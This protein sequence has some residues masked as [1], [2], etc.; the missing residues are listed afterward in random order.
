[1]KRRL[2]SESVRCAFFAALCLALCSGCSTV[3]SLLAKPVP[4]PP[5]AKLVFSDDFSKGLDNW[6]TEGVGSLAVV[7]GA[8]VMDPRVQNYDGYQARNLWCKQPL[9]VNF[10]ITM[11]VH[12]IA[13]TPQRKEPCNLLFALCAKMVDPARDVIKESPNR[14]Q[15]YIFFTGVKDWLK[16]PQAR[17]LAKREIPP[18]QNYT[19]TWYRIDKDGGVSLQVRKNPGYHLMADVPQV[20]LDVSARDHKIVIDKIDNSIKFYEDGRLWFETIDSAQ[21]GPVLDGGYFCFRTFLAKVAL[22]NFKIYKLP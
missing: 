1:M 21:N 6:V 12:P 20:L 10:R 7:N 17:H 22:D 4:L 3:S 14:D 15:S 2:L 18:M 8:V 11:D 19:I 13:P 16:Q 9:P 5:G